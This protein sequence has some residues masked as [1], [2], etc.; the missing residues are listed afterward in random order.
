MSAAQSETSGVAG[1]YATALFELA[2]E[3]GAI[4]S[5]AADLA[6]TQ[7]MIDESADLHRLGGA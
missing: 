5:V 3:S 4:D 2:V 7:S 1:R 6:Q